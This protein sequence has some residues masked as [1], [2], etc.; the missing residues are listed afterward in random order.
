MRK[1]LSYILVKI[2]GFT[3][4]EIAVWHLIHTPDYC[5]AADN[6]RFLILNMWLLLIGGFAVWWFSMAA[7]WD[8]KFNKK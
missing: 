7:L 1:I 6:I 2:I 8:L 3:M 4:M 5:Q